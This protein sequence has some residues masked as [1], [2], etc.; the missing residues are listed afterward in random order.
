MRVMMMDD[1]AEE[2]YGKISGYS[3]TTSYSSCQ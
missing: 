2:K 1:A 3:S